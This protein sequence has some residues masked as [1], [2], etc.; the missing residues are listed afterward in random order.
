MTES[1]R[2]LKIDVTV[3][4]Y[5][6]PS[7]VHRACSTRIGA[8]CVRAGG[9]SNRC[10]PALFADTAAAAVESS[11]RTSQPLTPQSDYLCPFCLLGMKQLEIGTFTL[12][13]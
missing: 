10:P 8:G 6:T 7:A 3:S 9:G 13:T 2:K 4:A 12:L 5:L 11:L 1:P